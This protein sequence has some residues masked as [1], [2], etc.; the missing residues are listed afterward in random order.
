MNRT[1]TYQITKTYD[2]IRSFLKQEGYPHGIL[3]RLKEHPERLVLNHQPSVMLRTPLFPGDLLEISILEENKASSQTIPVK[4]SLTIIYE[5]E[6][7][8]VLNKEAG[9]SIHPSIH[10]YEDSLA[11]AVMYHYHEED[12]PF[13]FRC[14]NRLDKETSGLTVIAKNPLSGALLSD[15]VQSRQIHRTYL[16]LVEGNLPIDS[17]KEAFPHTINAPIGR[18]GDSI[19]TRRIDREKG[20]NAITHY[21][22]LSNK[23]GLSLLSIKLETGRTHQIRVHMQFIGHP[24]PGDYLYHPVYD[25]INRVALHSASLTFSHPI[26]HEKLEF[27]APLP[28]DMAA[29]I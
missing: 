16:A 28:D 18:C 20:Q 21:R 1:I 8:L 23:K 22:V 9:M 10:H 29:L 6:D 19:I 11:N 26:T 4:A 5:D 24:L 14:I 12:S 17:D 3:A 27:H 15:M 13:V 2:Q 25:K 7:I